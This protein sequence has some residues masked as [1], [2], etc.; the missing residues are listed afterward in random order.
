MIKLLILP[1][2][3]ALTAIPILLGSLRKFVMS[4][5]ILLENDIILCNHKSKALYHRIGG[6][7]YFSV[8][9]ESQNITYHPKIGLAFNLLF[10]QN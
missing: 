8:C 6:F 2:V 4:R 1:I 5:Q 9:K 7:F 3:L 10:F